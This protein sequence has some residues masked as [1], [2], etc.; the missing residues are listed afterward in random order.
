MHIQTSID[1]IIENLLSNK[2]NCTTDIFETLCPNNC[3]GNGVCKFCKLK[4]LNLKKF[5][6]NKYF[7]FIQAQE[8]LTSGV[9]TPECSSPGKINF[10]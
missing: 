2:P 5:I 3:S 7:Y 8:C 9:I 10:I 1:E 4:F 6:A